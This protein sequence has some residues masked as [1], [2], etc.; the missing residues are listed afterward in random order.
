MQ[1]KPAMSRSLIALLWLL[2]G[3]CGGANL[4]PLLHV[5]L[6]R[7]AGELE[8][9]VGL[10]P[11]SPRA[12]VAGVLRAAVTDHLR[13]GA[14]AGGATRV[15]AD[16]QG[17]DLHVRH[18]ALHAEGFIGAEWGGLLFRV[19]ALAGS[20]YGVSRH[21]TYHCVARDAA[22]RCETRARFSPETRYV[23]S[24]FQLHL[25][26]APPGPLA[27]A[28]VLRVPF[29]SDLSSSATARE[30]DVSPELG[31]SQSLILRWLR[32]DLQGVWSD[33]QGAAFHLAVLLRFDAGRRAR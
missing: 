8:V 19:G 32:L 33:A 31:L 25:A 10:R 15:R 13:V 12:E 9:G 30:A 26:L 16:D 3:G 24:F 28:F 4:A 17:E 11:S 7:R 2:L 22:G 6:M 5:P 1:K 18:K 29:V 20:G 14:S 27:T 23:R 21:L